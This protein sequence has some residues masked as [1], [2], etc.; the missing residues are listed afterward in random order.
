MFTYMYDAE[1]FRDATIGLTRSVHE[2]QHLNVKTD[3]KQWSYIDIQI[4]VIGQNHL[5]NIPWSSVYAQR[6][7][8]RGEKMM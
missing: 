4:D 6:L 1:L 3:G 8:E 2:V 5:E 7:K